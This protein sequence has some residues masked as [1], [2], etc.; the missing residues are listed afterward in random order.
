MFTQISL[1]EAERKAFKTTVDDGLWDIL[2]GCY[3]LI[4]VIAP[5]LSVN[6]GD[7]WS[8]VVFLP[9][10]G[11]IYLVVRLIRKYIVRPRIGIVK[12]GQVRKAKLLK[13]KVA[14][15]VINTIALILGIVVAISYGG[16]H[17]QI[18]SFIFGIILLIGF[19]IAAYT[20]DISRLYVYGLLVFLSPLVGEYLWSLGYFT[21]HGFP[22]TFGV[23]AGIMILTGFVIFIRLLHKNPLPT[24]AITSQE[25]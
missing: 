20:L 15:L 21:H 17:G 7:F 3:F 12:F 22:I 24:E 6:L 5:Y 13:F 14:M 4:F 11:L 10:W 2:L 1:K 9:F 23:V 8:S 19:S 16:V 25:G 18:Y